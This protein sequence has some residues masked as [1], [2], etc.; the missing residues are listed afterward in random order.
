[1]NDEIICKLF[2]SI[3]S[4]NFRY[5]SLNLDNKY[6]DGLSLNWLC[7]QVIASE[8]E[9]KSSRA[10]KDAADILSTSPAALQLR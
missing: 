4:L 9:H 10:L 7:T 3:H 2:S 6:L 8:G 1:M 5:F